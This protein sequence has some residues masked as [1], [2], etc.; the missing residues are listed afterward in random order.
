MNEPVGMT[1]THAGV[2]FGSLQ[3]CFGENVIHTLH[4]LSHLMSIVNSYRL[5]LDCYHIF[6]RLSN[7][8][9]MNG[10]P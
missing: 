10:T 1:V 8:A 3:T 9:E 2:L 5:L 7:C 6:L 4:F